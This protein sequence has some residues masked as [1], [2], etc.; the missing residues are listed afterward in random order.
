[1]PLAGKV[2]VVLVLQWPCITDIR[3]EG[4]S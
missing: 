4:L 3:A 2:T 1:M